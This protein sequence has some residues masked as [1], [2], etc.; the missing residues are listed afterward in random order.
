MNLLSEYADQKDLLLVPELPY[1]TTSGKNVVP[2]GTLKDALRLDWGYYESKDTNDVLEDEIEKKFKKGYPNSNILFED[3]RIAILFQNGHIVGKSKIR[4]PEKLDKLLT[5]FLNYT[6]PEVLNFRKAL[7][8]FKT[9][10]PNVLTSLR[11]MINKQGLENKPFIAARKNFLAICQETINSEVSEADIDE[12]LIQHILTEQIFTSVFDDPTFHQEN[13]ISKEL[14]KLEQTF[15]TG[16]VKRSTL[17][18]IDPYYK[19]I[20]AQA[21]NITNHAEKQKFLKV[22]YENFYK[23]YNPKGADRLGIVYT[24]DE[25][26]K[27]MIESTDYLL[28]K[29]FHKTLGSDN[30]EILDPAT[31]TGTYICDII[32]YLPKDKLANKFK[33]ELHANEVAILPYYIANLNIE[34]TFKQ[35]MG[36]YE[37]FKNICF[38]DTLDNMAFGFK[39]KQTSMF[40]GLSAENADRVQRQNK[41]KIS[42]IIGNP[43]YNANQQNEND[44]NKNR[45][46]PKIDKRIK[47]TYIANSTAQKTK[48]YDMYARFL[49]WASDR[50]DENGVIAYITN[51]SYIDSRTFDGFRKSI[52]DE[53]EACY[54]ID[55]RSDV[56]ANPKISGTKNNVFGIQTG[57]SIMFLVKKKAAK[58]LPC[59]IYYF[60]LADEQTR[61]EKLTFFS[62]NKFAKISFD[63]VT[64]D[65]KNNW[66]NLTDNDFNTLIPVCSKDVKTTH[67]KDTEYAIFKLY[68]TGI[69]TNRDEWIIDFDAIN[70]EK[71]MK[72]F[73]D[74]YN[75]NPKSK[76]FDGTIKWSRN[77]KQRFGRGL[78]ESF[79]KRKIVSFNYRPYVP[80]KIYHS[81]LFIDEHGLAKQIFIKNNKA[82][83]LSGNNSS[84]PF[85]TLSVNTY[86]SLD[87]L[88]K[89]QCLPLYIYNEN[90]NRK[91]NITDWGLEQFQNHY[92]AKKIK[93]HTPKDDDYFDPNNLG[94]I[95]GHMLHEPEMEYGAIVISKEDIFYYTYAVLHDPAYR[96]KYE[97]NLKR[98]FPRLP[99]YKDFYQWVRWGKALMELHIDYESV[100]PAKLKRVDLK[101]DKKP[102][103]A[104]LM[105]MD[106][107][108]LKNTRT[109]IET[110]KPKLKANKE[111]GTI[112]IDEVTT[113]TGIPAEAW[114][115]RLGN[116]SALEWILDQY[117][118][119]KPKDPTIAEKF[120]TYKFADYKEHVIDLLMKVTTVSVETVK[121]IEEM[122]RKS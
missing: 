18:S 81:D 3:S 60:T 9:D 78:N 40:G 85:Q 21:S 113:L 12:M 76:V 58:K 64:P 69:S 59:D 52:S 86:M 80:S 83:C 84:K 37:E 55:T 115:Y 49:R 43:P 117:K 1:R 42:V 70:L 112:D 27:F 48:V 90:G 34:A 72:F 11:D 39:D 93:A 47:E 13:N 32:D 63:T 105:E 110:P 121:I 118:E 65:A 66:I 33:N 23:A 61:K 56:R 89:T 109:K 62:E 53:F 99:F 67:S 120:N 77:L 98:E 97:L 38:V 25:I 26:V 5:V 96:R 106:S 87:L 44:N 15:F 79:D 29:H 91:D 51:R 35:K 50:L 19:I 114:E 4:E 107:T 22:V 111:N 74:C 104:K 17:D 122:E 71:K 100:A 24:P 54:I 108:Q 6:R 7:D 16:T 95:R 73:I 30:V 88:E 41:R 57:V 103:Q 116:R 8:Q 119:S 45:E 75:R 94:G 28:H 92:G 68:S 36:Y 102:K 2:D 46:Y 101:P 10:L 82:I 14:Q 20:K 31:G